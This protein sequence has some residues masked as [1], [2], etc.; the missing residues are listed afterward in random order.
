VALRPVE[1]TLRDTLAWM[2]AQGILTPR[3]AGSLAPLA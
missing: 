2:L 1:E 3:Q